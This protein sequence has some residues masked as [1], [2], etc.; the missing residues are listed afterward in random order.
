MS[1]KTKED[2]R[3]D[4]HSRRLSNE[5]SVH[6]CS[7]EVY[8][9]GAPV[10]VP[11]KWE[12]Q[13]GTPRVRFHEKPLPPLTPPPSFLFNPPRTP[14]S[15]SM[16]KPKGGILHAVIP[17]LITFTGKNHNSPVSST[18]SES[19]SLFSNSSYSDS[20][21]SHYTPNNNRRNQRKSFEHQDW[22]GSPVS[23]LCFCIRRA[24]TPKST[25]SRSGE[26]QNC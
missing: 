12:S 6:F 11:F 9:G 14:N 8:Y 22:F 15:K 10:A 23:T 20:S 4:V 25:R 19:S 13:P 3:F 1:I 21:S 7:T 17:R 16:S 5:M 2:S 24:V 26:S 18:S